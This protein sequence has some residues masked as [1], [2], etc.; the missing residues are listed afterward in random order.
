MSVQTVLETCETIT[1]L[2]EEGGKV[3]IGATAGESDQII[4]TVHS[5]TTAT[6]IGGE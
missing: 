6:T 1:T 3:A 5:T 2:V 4:A